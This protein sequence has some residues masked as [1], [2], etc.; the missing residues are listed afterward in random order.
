MSEFDP[1]R[2][3][4]ELNFYNEPHTARRL[5]EQY[6]VSRSTIT[7]DAVIAKAISAIGEV[8][9]DVKMDILSGKT[10]ITRKQLHELTN[11][12]DNDVSNIVDKIVDG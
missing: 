8:S 12:T 2:I 6:N 7:R 1:G 11:G 10:H 3:R 4:I 9:P 5:A